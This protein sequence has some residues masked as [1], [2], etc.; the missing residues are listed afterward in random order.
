MPSPSRPHWN[1]DTIRSAIALLVARDGTHCWLCG[2]DTHRRSRSVDHVIPYVHRP[3]LDQVTS[4][5][6]LAHLNSA[7]TPR[8]C[9]QDGCTCTGNTGRR[10]T[11]A[12]PPPS[13]SW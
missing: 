1:A 10:H 13:R 2:H 7:G 9:D 4:N 12:T 8:G 5:W 6:K 3:D 11:P